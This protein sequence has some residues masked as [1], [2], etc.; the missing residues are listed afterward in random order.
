MITSYLNYATQ[1]AIFFR[2][3]DVSTVIGIAFY[4]SLQSLVSYNK[5]QFIG[6]IGVIALAIIAFLLYLFY[7]NKYNNVQIIV[8]IISVVGILLFIWSIYYTGY[9]NIS[10]IQF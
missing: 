2:V 8:H 5:T 9:K 7:G 4:Y 10:I 6:Y 1:N 3:I